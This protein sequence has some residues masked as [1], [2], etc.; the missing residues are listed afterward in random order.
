M[1]VFNGECF[2]REA[3]EN[4]LK[5]RFTECEFIFVDK[6]VRASFSG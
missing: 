4:I 2:L 3:V 6:S 5:Q 1:S